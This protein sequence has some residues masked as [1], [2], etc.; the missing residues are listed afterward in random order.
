MPVELLALVS[1]ECSQRVFIRHWSVAG[2]GI[3]MNVAAPGHVRSSLQY[4]L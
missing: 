2:S 1:A 3:K 4:L